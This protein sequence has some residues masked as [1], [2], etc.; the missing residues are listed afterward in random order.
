MNSRRAISY[1]AALMVLAWTIGTLARSGP[2]KGGVLVNSYWLFYLVSAIPV[3]ALGAM[4]AMVVFLA[5]NWK[6]FSDALGFGIARRRAQKKGSSA[7]RLIVWMGFW[8]LAL[9]TL[10]YRCGGI[11]CNSSNNSTQTLTM[12][13]NQVSPSGPLPTIPSLLSAAPAIANL[14]GSEWFYL[15]FLGLL[16]I[17]SVIIARSVKVSMDE[18][19][20][21]NLVRLREVQ[22]QGTIAVQEALQLLQE[23]E[24]VEPRT[25]ILACYQ[26]MMR[27]AADLGAPIGPDQTARELESGIRGMFMLKGRGLH[28]LTRL[29]EEARYSLHQMLEQD[30]TLAHECLVEI[31]DELR[32]LVSVQA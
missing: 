9:A 19:R 22:E 7:I 1:L 29:F 10:L 23:G 13:T 17:S 26:R 30:A 20:H 15:T 5:F 16:V 12:I 25:R 8:G 4:I 18:T 11:F 6:L 31:G 27:A 2:G 24:N 21:A 28:E 32:S 14:V 3:I